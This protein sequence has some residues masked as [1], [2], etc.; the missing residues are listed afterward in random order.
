MTRR[1]TVVAALPAAAPAN[2]PWI[3]IARGEL[4]VRDIPGPQYNPRVLQYLNTTG[5]DA[6]DDET[7]WCSAFVN[8]T[9]IQAQFPGTNNA[10]ARSWLDYGRSLPAARPGCIVVL[11]RESPTSWKG[12]VGFFDGWD[13]A[14]NSRVRLL[15]GNQGGG[16]DWDEVCVATFPKER[17]LGFR[18][19]LNYP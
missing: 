9:M 15:A 17:I 4:G 14:G 8:W 1:P 18:W 13:G 5:H 11:W 6:N 7:S 2:P 10:A 12:H 19:P 3:D 16:V